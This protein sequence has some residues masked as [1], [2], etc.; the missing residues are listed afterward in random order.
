VHVLPE[1]RPG[2]ASEQRFDVQPLRARDNTKHDDD[3]NEQETETTD[4]PTTTTETDS[5]HRGA[6]GVR[7]VLRRFVFAPNGGF[8][9]T[10]RT[11]EDV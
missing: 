4:E 11:N 6:P 3:D 9:Q 10:G 5:H 7:G 2:D 8:R 1:V